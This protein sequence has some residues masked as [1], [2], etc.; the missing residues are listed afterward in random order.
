[1]NGLLIVFL[2]T[3]EMVCNK[4]LMKLSTLMEHLCLNK[5]NMKLKWTLFIKVILGICEIIKVMMIFF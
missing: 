4:I 2:N 5:V 3:L 1:M